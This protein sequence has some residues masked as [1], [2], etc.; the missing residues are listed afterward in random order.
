MVDKILE[1]YFNQDLKNQFGAAAKK[2]S[3]F[4]SAKKFKRE[5]LSVI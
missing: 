5:F 4:F 3:E 2:R 1:I